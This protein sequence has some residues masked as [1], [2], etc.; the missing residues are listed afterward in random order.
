MKPR[1]RSPP[2]ISAAMR[3]LQPKPMLMRMPATMLGSAPGPREQRVEEDEPENGVEQDEERREPADPEP[4]D[5]E[6]DPGDAGDGVGE[7]A[8]GLEGVAET[9]IHPGEDAER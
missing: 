1:P 8:D 6:R 5:G 4:D 7:Y 9:A 3:A 2:I